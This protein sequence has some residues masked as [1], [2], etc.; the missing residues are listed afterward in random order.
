M[1][2]AAVVSGALRVK[3]GYLFSFRVP[4]YSSACISQNDFKYLQVAVPYFGYKF[5]VFPTIPQNLYMSCKTNL[6]F[7][8]CFEREKPTLKLNQTGLVH[9]QEVFKK[10]IFYLID[11]K[12][13]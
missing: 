1:W 12:I 6:D 10:E 4:T 2:F 8:D 7:G 9:I 13:W 3:N 5:V 11:K